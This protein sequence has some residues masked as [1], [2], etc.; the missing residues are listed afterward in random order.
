[1][2]YLRSLSLIFTV[3]LPGVPRVTPSGRVLPIIVTSKVSSPS[4]ILSSVIGILNGT[5]VV[6]AGN[7]TVYGPES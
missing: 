1:M 2:N 6:P 3:A 5:V 7:V 4:N